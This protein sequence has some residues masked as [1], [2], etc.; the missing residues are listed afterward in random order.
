MT[1]WKAF[2]RQITLLEHTSDSR[3]EFQKFLLWHIFDLFIQNFQAVVP[4]LFNAL[5]NTY[6][7]DLINHDI[8]KFISCFHCNSESKDSIYWDFLWTTITGVDVCIFIIFVMFNT[9]EKCF[10]D[11]KELLMRSEVLSSPSFL[12]F[13]SGNM[14]SSPSISTN[15]NQ[16]QMIL[17]SNKH[18]SSQK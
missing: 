18:V 8:Y 3:P 16:I 4:I 14:Y 10:R 13:G 12:G 5:V 9:M 17:H 1:A 7:L 6:V 11:L 15:L 2:S